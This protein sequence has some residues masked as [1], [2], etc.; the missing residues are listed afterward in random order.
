MKPSRKVVFRARGSYVFSVRVWASI[1]SL[2]L[3][4][5]LYGEERNSGLIWAIPL[6]SLLA[7]QLVLLRPRI[8]LHESSLTIVRP[9]S[10][11]TYPRS[12]VDGVDLSAGKLGT[13]NQL[14]LCLVL[15]GAPTIYRWISWTDWQAVGI[16][17]LQ[18]PIERKKRHAKVVDAMRDWISGSEPGVP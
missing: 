13:T 18:M 17:L 1:P 8:V 7:T 15:Q 11:E 9:F 5:L 14:Y 10:L 4:M 2:A 6:V 16:G 3:W 12:A